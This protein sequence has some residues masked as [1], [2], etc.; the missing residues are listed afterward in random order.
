MQKSESANLLKYHMKW[1]PKIIAFL[2]KSNYSRFS[3]TASKPPG[4]PGADH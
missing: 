2:V 3:V 1:Q 4:F